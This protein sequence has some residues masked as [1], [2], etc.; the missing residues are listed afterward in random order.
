MFNLEL[1]TSSADPRGTL[2]REFGS[3]E[4]DPRWKDLR[5]TSSMDPG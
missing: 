1:M 3:S 4:I 5:V 2:D